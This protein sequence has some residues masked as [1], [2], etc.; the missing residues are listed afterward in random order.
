MRTAMQE[1]K[2][3]DS[4]SGSTHSITLSVPASLAP[5]TV[6]FVIQVKPPP[7]VTSGSTASGSTVSG[8]TASV[9][10]SGVSPR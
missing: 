2:A 8:S 6:A 5:L 7:A 10:S 4:D 9:R 3:A 1:V